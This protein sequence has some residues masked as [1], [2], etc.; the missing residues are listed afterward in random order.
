MVPLRIIDILFTH[1]RFR[2]SSSTP[3]SWLKRSFSAIWTALLI[4]LVKTLLEAS[5]RF[6]NYIWLS[7]EHC[8]R[9]I[10]VIWYLM[11]QLFNWVFLKILIR[12]KIFSVRAS[13]LIMAGIVP[14]VSVLLVYYGG[15]CSMLCCDRIFIC[16]PWFTRVSLCYLVLPRNWFFDYCWGA[17]SSQRVFFWT[18]NTI[19]WNSTVHFCD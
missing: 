10:A 4:R 18:L 5:W 3:T 7:H 17:C 14:L 15:N 12:C 1:W 11:V 16:E 13:I 9:L 19:L 2:F 8:F 6:W